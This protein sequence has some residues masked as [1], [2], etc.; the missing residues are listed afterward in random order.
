MTLPN[1]GVDILFPNT[2][3]KKLSI[4]FELY[5]DMLKNWSEFCSLGVLGTQRES[6]EF[7][8]R[9]KF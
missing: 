6:K 1:E 2:D 3:F 9:D 5:R 7:E 8:E 4:V